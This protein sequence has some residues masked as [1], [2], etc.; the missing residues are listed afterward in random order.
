LA[1]C[2]AIETLKFEFNWKYPNNAID[3]HGRRLSINHQDA[4]KFQEENYLDCACIVFE[5]Q[6]LRDVVD[7]RGPHGVRIVHNGVLDFSGVWVGK[8]GV[9]D[10]T[11]GAASHSGEFLDN[12]KRCG[13][14]TMDVT[15]AKVPEKS[16]EFY[17]SLSA[18]MS[19]D[20]SRFRELSVRILDSDNLGHQLVRVNIPQSSLVQKEDTAEITI[21]CCMSR[22]ARGCWG[23]AGVNCSSLGGARDYRPILL[24]LRAIQEKKHDSTPPQWPHQLPISGDLAL[25]GLSS[26]SSELLLPPARLDQPNLKRYERQSSGTSSR[27]EEEVFHLPPLVSHAKTDQGKHVKMAV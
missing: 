16:T 8:V 10:A 14:C 25:I 24:G 15:L 20:I 23:A 17:F 18:P 4:V 19:G 11:G 2:K 12:A 3:S 9:G 7:Y 27:G 22:D 6:A 5:G 26:E 13:R 21:A 1:R